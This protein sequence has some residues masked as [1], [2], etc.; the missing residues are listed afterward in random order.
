MKVKVRTYERPSFRNVSRCVL[1]F[2]FV[3]LFIFLIN[4]PVGPESWSLMK[5]SFLKTLISVFSTQSRKRP[6]HVESSP[7]LGKTQIPFQ[8]AQDLKIGFKVIHAP[9]LQP[10]DYGFPVIGAD[11]KSVD[12]VVSTEKFPIEGADCPEVGIFLID[13]IAQADA[14]AQK[15]L[16]NLI[17]ERE[18]HGKRLKAG[19]TIVTTGNRVSDRAGANRLL[20]HLKNRLTTVELEASLDDWTNWALENGVK[21]EV[22]AFVRFRPELLNSFD[23]NND[24]NATPRA[25][26]EGVS[27]SLGV[28]EPNLE[29]ETFKGDVGQGAAAEFCGFLKVYRKLPS[30]DAIMLNPDKADVPTDGATLYALCGA[31]SHKATGATFLRLM[32]YMKRLPSEFGL[33][34]VRDAVKLCPEIQ[35]TKEFIKWASTDGAK[36]LS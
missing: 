26:S 5:P 16:A 28:V 33:L 36:L 14:S 15:I 17:Q 23:S 25:W 18:I 19:W 22:I 7:G 30:P 31:L 29:L 24:I 13:E 6:L 3:S 11:R 20:S 2:I 8:V 12:F 1:C 10:E 21:P 9:L 35:T 34:F 32:Q 4:G 27:K